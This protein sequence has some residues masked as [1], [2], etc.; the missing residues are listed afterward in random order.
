MKRV[1]HL[2]WWLILFQIY[3][4]WHAIVMSQSRLL[5]YS[6]H[7]LLC[8]LPRKVWGGGGGSAVDWINNILECNHRIR[9]SY[10]YLREVIANIEPNN[11][12]RSRILWEM[13]KEKLNWNFIYWCTLY[14]TVICKTFYQYFQHIYRLFFIQLAFWKTM[15]YLLSNKFSR[16]YCPQHLLTQIKYRLFIFSNALRQ[17]SKYISPHVRLLS[18]SNWICL[19]FSQIYNLL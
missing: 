9:F 14:Y 19:I 15:K 12:T 11:T 13:I 16:T 2:L 5:G 8:L 17:G 1:E 4:S 18:I 6:C 3:S 10:C 7:V